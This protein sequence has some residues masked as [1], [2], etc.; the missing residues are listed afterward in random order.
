MSKNLFKREWK[1]DPLG[2]AAVR[3]EANGLRA[4]KTWDDDSVCL[5]SDLRTAA[6]REQRKVKIAEL[7]TLCGIKFFELPQQQWKYKGRICYHGDNIFDAHG[8][9]VLFEE[10]ATTPTS[11]VALNLALFFGCRD[12]NQVNSTDGNFG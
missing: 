12:G 1:S 8:N 6:R 3:K 10:T 11:L 7:L 5:L 9:H 4:N 2:V